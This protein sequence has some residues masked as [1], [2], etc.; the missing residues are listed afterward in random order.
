MLDLVIADDHPIV[1]AGLTQLFRQEAGVRVVASCVNGVEALDAVRVHRPDV[2]LL[3]LNMPKLDGFGVLRTLA[4]EHSAVGV[5]VLTAD[6]SASDVATARAAGA[7][8]IVLKELSPRHVVDCVR[9]VYSG[10]EWVEFIGR[11]REAAPTRAT[12]GHQGTF[13]LTPRE[14][15]LMS[16]V[17]SGLRN[18]DVAAQLGIS[19]G[20]AK[21]HLYN[22]Y[23]KLG[24][25]NRVEL[26]LRARSAGLSEA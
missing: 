7:R 12:G 23:K 20:T 16:L 13:G 19:E 2:L 10:S 6:A 5:V 26:V 15:E 4:S 21:L 1:L 9:F 17:V 25:A 22:V 3:D 8:G 14:L 24:V 18:R 11:P